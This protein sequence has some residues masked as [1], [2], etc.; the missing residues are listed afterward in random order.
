MLL[1]RL[2]SCY[3]KNECLSCHPIHVTYKLDFIVKC[4][5]KICVIYDIA[6]QQ[7]F[8]RAVVR[9]TVFTK[10]KVKVKLSRNTKTQKWDG[11]L[12]FQPYFDID[13][14]SKVQPSAT[15]AAHILP[16]R[17]IPWYSFLLQAEWPAGLPN[18]ARRNRSLENFQG[19][20]L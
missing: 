7:C 19:P 14:T 16:P 1:T 9:K 20:H 13:T 8:L 17:T 18:A 3:L 6:E 11:M 4:L 5:S 15:H 10:R 12:G 2:S